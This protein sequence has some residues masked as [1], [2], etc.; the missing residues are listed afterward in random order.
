MWF[1][2][3]EFE[4]LPRVARPSRKPPGKPLSQKARERVAMTKLR[5]MA[6][7]QKEEDGKWGP[8]ERWQWIPALLG[9][10]VE[11]DAPKVSRRPWVT[12]GMAVVA[13]LVTAYTVHAAFAGESSEA[14]SIFLEWGFIPAEWG[15]HG[16]LTLVTSFFLHGGIFH[17]LSNMYFCSCSGTT[18]RTISAAGSIFCSLPWRTWAAES[19]TACSTPVPTYRSWG[20]C[21]C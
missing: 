1:D 7:Q 8:T 17:L 3:S 21:S 10:P 11:Y 9:M 6:E 18:S 19:C 5:V 4:S 12:W 14:G 2:A 15:R 16:G 13:T 20:H